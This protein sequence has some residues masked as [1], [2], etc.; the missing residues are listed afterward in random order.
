MTSEEQALRNALSD[1][2]VTGQPVAPHDR[3]DGVR[4]RHAQRQQ[5]RIVALGAAV[6]VAVVGVALGAVGLRAGRPAADE[7]VHRD[8]PK[9]A[10]QWPEHRD[11]SIPDAYLATAYTSWRLDHPEIAVGSGAQVVWYVA[12]PIPGGRLALAFEVGG[13]DTVPQFVVG[14]TDAKSLTTYRTVHFDKNTSLWDRSWATAGAYLTSSSVLGLYSTAN[15]D[16]SGRNTV[17]L[18]TGPRAR[19]ADLTY[20]ADSG[21]VSR[22]VRMTAGFM[23]VELGPL[24]TRVHVDAVRAA[25]GR[26]LAGDL[27]VGIPETD[28]DPAA[29][30]DSFRPDLMPIPPLADA[31]ANAPGPGEMAGQE[32]FFDASLNPGW[33]LH[34]TRIY[35]RCFGRSRSL[36][37]H[38]DSD[39]PAQA[40]T[41]PCD[42]REHVVDG[43]GFLPTGTTMDTSNLYPGQHGVVHTADV[44]SD[45]ETAWRAV[46]V[47]R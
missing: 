21:R 31:P 40:V 10:V 9:W 43:P 1:I 11:R 25:D 3:I 41:V 44:F 42:D 34:S 23:A 4:R 8:L 24:R 15:A 32:S 13:V 29:E 45:G 2:A 36:A 27:D 7:F 26:R 39:A 30:S 47:A 17:V 18:L 33:P 28:G 46:V 37:V 35:A 12:E 6:V 5:R 16:L 14:V 20:V 22:T 38:I 19:S